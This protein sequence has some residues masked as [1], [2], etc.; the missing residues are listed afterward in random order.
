MARSPLQLKQYFFTKINCEA[1]LNYKDPNPK[2]GN[3]LEVKVRSNIA[4]RKDNEKDW[5]VILDI[6]VSSPDK[7][8]P[9]K[10][11]LQVTGFFEV[12]TGYPENKV[13]ELIRITGASLLYS[14]AREFVLGIT[15][16][17]PW[18]PVLLPTISFMEPNQ[19]GEPKPKKSRKH[20]D[21]ST[22]KGSKR[23]KIRL[24]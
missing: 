24:T 23:E 17:G 7:P 11:D 19:Q 4:P 9:Y 10:L 3:K 21:T 12:V 20:R 6:N 18:V 2:A 16:R 22:S 8:M 13:R 14:G 15:S 5:R 1:D